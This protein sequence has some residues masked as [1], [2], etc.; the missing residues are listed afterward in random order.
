MKPR[1][2]LAFAL[3]LGTA[4]FGAGALA[5]QPPPQSAGGS[6]NGQGMYCVPGTAICVKV[7]GNGN[8]NGQVTPPPAPT[9]VPPPPPTY[10]PPPPPPP[11]TYVPPPVA[12][13]PPAS[14]PPPTNNY[15]VGHG[16]FGAGFAA[17]GVARVGL[18]SGYHFGG[19]LAIPYRQANVGFDFVE[20]QVTAGGKRPTVDVIVAPV[21]ALFLFGG[22]APWSHFYVRLGLQAG[23]SWSTRADGNDFFRF[24]GHAGIGYERDFGSVTLRL[25]DVRISGEVTGADADRIGNRYDLGITLSSGIIFR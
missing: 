23:Y 25:A 22:D 24:G 15:S 16:S 10:V 13:P 20:T 9:Y 6:V 12:P 19:C 21:S 18:W 1:V 3:A 17:C 7:Q 8:G 4:L 2:A 5:Q 11:P 14:P